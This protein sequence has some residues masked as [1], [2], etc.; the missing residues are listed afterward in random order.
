MKKLFIFLGLVSLSL[1]IFSSC[2]LDDSFQ[3][4]PTLQSFQGIL[5]EQTLT[6]AEPGTHILNME[7]EIIPLR[8]LVLNLSGVKYLDN[9]VEVIGSFVEDDSVFEVTGISI[10]EVLSENIDSVEF[11]EYTNTDMGFEMKYYTDWEL[12]ESTVGEVLFSAPAI[13][14]ATPDVVKVSR[15]TFSYQ[16]EMD[17]E[18]NTDTPLSSFMSESFPLI[19]DISD[20]IRHIGPQKHD[21]IAME[22]DGADVDYYLFRNNQIYTV[23]FISSG[24][25][26]V[27]NKKIFN[28]MISEFLFTGY[29]VTGEIK[30]EEIDP[31]EALTD[32]EEE[33]AEVFEMLTAFPQSDL[34]MAPFESLSY[35]FQGLY[36]ASWYYAGAS[37]S[38]AGV[39]R[40]YG[41]SDESL[42]DDNELIGL[43][44]VSGSIPAGK[45]HS[46]ADREFI[47]LNEN[48]LYT[49]YTVVD[50]KNYRVYGPDEYGDLI[51]SMA[52]G[53]DSISDEGIDD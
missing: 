42:S 28:D 31:D 18:G 26:V 38:S 11:A 30:N 8:S 25:Y 14:V 23:S 15:Y 46:F 40:H 13:E 29:T 43:D 52:A 44:L 2:G 22:T 16:P 51:L 37:S 9:K 33:E 12:D 34:K 4:D 32:E 45:K 49:I 36:P 41:F 53:I 35:E 24:D 17:E 6:S 5:S 19:E 1:G 50:G 39:L 48:G 3:E 27:G 47:T 20:Y 7:N 10:I 21:A